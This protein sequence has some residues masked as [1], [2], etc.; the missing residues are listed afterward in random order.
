VTQTIGNPLDFPR[1]VIRFLLSVVEWELMSKK[2]TRTLSLAATGLLLAAGAVRADSGLGPADAENTLGSLHYRCALQV[3]C[4]L[5]AANYDTLKKAIAGERGNQFFLGLNLISGDGAPMDRKAG[6]AWIAKAAEAGLPF[7]ARYVDDKL[8]NGEDIEVDETKVA[9][10]LKKQADVGGVE[11]MRALAPMMIR[12]RGTEQNPQAGIALLLKAAEQGKGG[13]IEQ[14]IADLYLIGTNGLAAD[15]EE[16]M[17]W[18]AIAASRGNVRAMATLDCLALSRELGN[19][20]AM[21]C[22]SGPEILPGRLCG[23]ELESFVRNAIMPQ[24]HP[25]GTAKMGRDPLSVVDHRLRV[26]GIDGLT[27]ADASVLPR[28]P[29]GNTMAPCVV[30]GERASDILK[31]EHEI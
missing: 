30:I 25:C 9:T 7:A 20:P 14:Q 4:P 28:A 29:T 19:A 15:H 12:G 24:W 26:Y 13:E 17:K 11:S 3:L 31:I 18:Y 22:F 5:S 8:R 27:I 6:L 23:P 1:E 2:L 21:R 16:G 10:A